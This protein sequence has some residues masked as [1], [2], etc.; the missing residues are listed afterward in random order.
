M[1]G[2]YDWVFFRCSVRIR[3]FL[4]F[5]QS[6]C[7]QLAEIPIC[8]TLYVHVCERANRKISDS[9]VERKAN[10][11]EVFFCAQF[12]CMETIFLLLLSFVFSFYFSQCF[13]VFYPSKNE[14]T[15]IFDEL[16]PLHLNALLCTHTHTNG[17]KEICWC[18]VHHCYG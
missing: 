11:K 12:C 5:Y 13:I 17:H 15:R 9:F 18:K 2:N 6:N 16:C 1:D 7:V 8:A 14:S 10:A 3:R 4:L